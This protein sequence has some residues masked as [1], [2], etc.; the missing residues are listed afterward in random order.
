M[1]LLNYTEFND[2]TSP[3]SCAEEENWIIEGSMSHSALIGGNM[4]PSSFFQLVI[5]KTIDKRAS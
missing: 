4:H 3:Y 5:D 1:S 2:C